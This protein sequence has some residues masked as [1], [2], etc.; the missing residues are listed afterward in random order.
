[1]DGVEMAIT[2]YGVAIPTFERMTPLMNQEG[3]VVTREWVA[4]FDLTVHQ[5]S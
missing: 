3:G 5:G 2:G 4:D 1:V